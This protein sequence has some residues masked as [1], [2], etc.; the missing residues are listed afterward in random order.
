MYNKKTVLDGF[1]I[2]AMAVLTVYLN[3]LKVLARTK[4]RQSFVRQVLSRRCWSVEQ[5]KNNIKPNH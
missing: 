1:V 5:K 3:M 4:E 2:F